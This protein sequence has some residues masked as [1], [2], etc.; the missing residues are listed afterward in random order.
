MRIK[1]GVRMKITMYQVDAFTNELFKGNPVAVCLTEKPLKEALMQKIAMENNLSETA[2][3]YKEGECYQIRWFTPEVEIDLCG[4][5]TLGTAYVLFNEVEQGKKQITF[6]S[7]SGEIIVTRNKERFT[8]SFPVREGRAITP[9]T[10]IIKALGGNPIAFYE[11]RDVM[12]V[13][14]T[15]EEIANL[16]PDVGLVNRLDV[17]GIIVTAKGNEVDFV[18]RYFAPGCGV[19][20]DPATGS[21]HCTLVPYWAKILGKN[22]F[23]DKQLSKRVGTFYCEL[24]EDKVYI[25]GE[26]IQLFKTSFEIDLNK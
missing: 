5:A 17:F 3:C 20:E 26:A 8:L 16:K 11:S 25:S 19:F 1:K 21:S 2:F 18:S 22:Q 13:Y 4:H 9:R 12:V 10:D 23:L 24:K 14:E 15:E 6:K 7:Q